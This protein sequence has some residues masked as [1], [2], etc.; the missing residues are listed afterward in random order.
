MFNFVITPVTSFAMPFSGMVRGVNVTPPISVWYMTE[1]EALYPIYH[2]TSH[3]IL[4]VAIIS[5]FMGAFYESLKPLLLYPIQHLIYEDYDLTLLNS[6]IP[7]SFWG[8]S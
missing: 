2:H 5:A 8:A 7:L 3:S 4:A 1:Q 6:P